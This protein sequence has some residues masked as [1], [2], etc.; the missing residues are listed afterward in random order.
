MD[1]LSNRL[2]DVSVSLHVRGK[3][4]SIT[5]CTTKPITGKMTNLLAVNLACHTR[6]S[7]RGKL[8]TS[9]HET[10]DSR[11]CVAPILLEEINFGPKL[12]SGEFSNVYEIESFNLK[13]D[14]DGDTKT[15]DE[16]KKRFLLQRGDK[17]RQTSQCRYALKHLKR[18]YFE[19]HDSDTYVQA[20]W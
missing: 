20:A 10:H 4:E 13:D 12:G 14:F 8:P 11:D 16:L 18:E 17:Y 1:A 2:S 7:F 3:D 19:E 15:A 6:D 5:L 9:L